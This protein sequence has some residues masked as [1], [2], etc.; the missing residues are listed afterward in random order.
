[1][2]EFGE[3]LPLPLSGDAEATC[4]HTGAFYRLRDGVLTRD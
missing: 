2:S 1:M 3:Q 4:E